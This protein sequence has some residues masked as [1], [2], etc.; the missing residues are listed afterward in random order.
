[1]LDR[2]FL[3]Q[4]DDRAQFT[5]CLERAEIRSALLYLAELGADSIWLE[6]GRFT[7]SLSLG[8]IL[9]P[10]VGLVRMILAQLAVTASAIESVMAGGSQERPDAFASGALDDRLQNR[11]DESHGPRAHAQRLA[12]SGP[13][14][15]VEFFVAVVLAYTIVAP[16]WHWRAEASVLELATLMEIRTGI[17]ALGA[18]A[19]GFAAALLAGGRPIIWGVGVSWPML[20][21]STAIWAYCLILGV[22]SSGPLAGRS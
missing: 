15:V 18:L 9:P 6:H 5:K 19:M 10:R 8:L 14:I 4:F 13:L 12:F 7:A 2:R 17:A 21:Y 16:M 11:A 3:F 22:R 20:F 1:M